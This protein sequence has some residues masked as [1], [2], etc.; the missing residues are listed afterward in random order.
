MTLNKLILVGDIGGTN[1]RFAIADAHTLEIS[2]T[3]IRRTAD[4]A[5]MREAIASYLEQEAA[6]HTPTHAA[7]A[8]A[9]PVGNDAIKLT[10]NHWQFSVREL[11][12]QLNLTE[13]R[14]LNDF[15]AQALAIPH[16]QP[17]DFTR[18]G[19]DAT[20]RDNEAI[21]VLGPGTGLGVSGL[22]PNGRGGWSALSGEGGH[23]GIV[24]ETEEEIQIIRYAWQEFGRTSI[25]RL[26]CGSG[27]AF[28][29]RALC[30]VR[31][32]SPQPYTEQDITRLALSGECALC[33]DSIMQF[34]AFLGGFAGDLALVLGAHGGIYI[35]GGV[36]PRFGSLFDASP[37]RLRF[38]NKGRFTQFN[39]AIPTYVVAPTDNPAL[40]GAASV[41]QEH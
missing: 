38:E 1:A 19:P 41:F 6:G 16:L 23:A 37:F 9:S 20:P 17:D 40:L 21:G 31:K 32:H 4:F 11:Q 8:V 39:A 5:G 34:C 25:E 36:V 28:L 30:H 13:L 22:I 33:R 29:Y 10:N 3:G 15:T 18:I 2:H 35:A 12:S 26:I 27:I 24:P 14:L 7:I